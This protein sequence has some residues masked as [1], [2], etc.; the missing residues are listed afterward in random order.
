MESDNLQPVGKFAP[1]WDE[2]LV[3]KMIDLQQLD[4]LHVQQHQ[5]TKESDQLNTPN[6]NLQIPSPKAPKRIQVGVKKLRT[7]PAKKVLKRTWDHDDMED[8]YHDHNAHLD[9]EEEEEEVP[10]HLWT[11]AHMDEMIV[12]E[13]VRDMRKQERRCKRVKEER[14]LQQIEKE[15]QKRENQQNAEYQ[16]RVAQQFEQFKKSQNGTDEDVVRTNL[17]GK[18][19]EQII[20]PPV[21]KPDVLKRAPIGRKKFPP[22]KLNFDAE[23]DEN[24]R[25]NKK[26]EMI[27]GKSKASG[28]AHVVELIKHDFS[29]KLCFLIQSMDKQTNKVISR[30]TFGPKKIPMYLTRV[31]KA[32]P[33]KSHEIAVKMIE[34]LSEYEF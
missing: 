1:H 8:P 15:E 25:T 13:H 6:I 22:R 17:D 32:N 29:K 5:Q 24:V 33:Q 19:E 18:M 27:D 11:E 30:E 2:N 16:K 31:M 12:N 3:Q 21:D 26:G 10:D 28:I 34:L 4:D 9:E 14:R 7:S 23:E 20:Q